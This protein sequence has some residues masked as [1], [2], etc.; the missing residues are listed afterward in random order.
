MPKKEPMMSGGIRQL[1]K[2]RTSKGKKK[3]LERRGKS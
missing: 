1:N 2:I 3:D